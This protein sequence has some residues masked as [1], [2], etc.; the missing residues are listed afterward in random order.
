MTIHARVA[1]ARQQLRDAGISLPEADLDARLLAQHVLGWTAEQFLT[2]AQTAEPDG[3]APHYD[4]LVALLL[5][6]GESIR[7][8]CGYLAS[9]PHDLAS[10]TQ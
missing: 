1:D 5:P 3:F 7:A 4:T 6:W 10:A 8:A 9:G 2:D